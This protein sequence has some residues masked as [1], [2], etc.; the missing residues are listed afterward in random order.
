MRSRASIAFNALGGGVVQWS[1]RLGVSASMITKY[2]RG[3]ATPRQ[4]VRHLIHEAGGPAPDEWDEAAAFP[5]PRAV[6]PLATEPATKEAVSRTADDL[7]ADIRNVRERLIGDTLGDPAAQARQL[8]ELAQ[9]MVQLG[10]MTDV[11]IVLSERQIL[12]SPNWSV[13]EAAIVEA[14]TPHPDAMAAVIEALQALKGE[15]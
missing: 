5:Q 10:K 4:A 15:S 13:I 11:G 1:Q 9:A 7:L 14:L 8:R 2:R 6:T 12:A 3:E